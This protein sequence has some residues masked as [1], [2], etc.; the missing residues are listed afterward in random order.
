MISGIGNATALSQVSAQSRAVERTAEQANSPQSEGVKRTGLLRAAATPAGVNS[1]GAPRA[2]NN[3]LTAEAVTTVQ[4]NQPT[5]NESP[6]KAATQDNAVTELRQ[7]DT[8]VRAQERTTAP[9]GDEIAAAPSYDDETGGQVAVDV[10]PVEGNPDA[11]ADKME[12]VKAAALAPSSP[13]GQDRAVAV[14]ADATRTEAMVEL[15]KAKD[16]Q[17]QQILNSESGSRG[18]AAIRGNE[19]AARN[20]LNLL[21]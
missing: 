6:A 8:E 15:N 2:V 13:S 21:V 12:Q 19:P 1:S 10:A 5:D 9:G 17:A 3:L 4:Q 11:P 16:E 14:K 20:P 18:G 7:R